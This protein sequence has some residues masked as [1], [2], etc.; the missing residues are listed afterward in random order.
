MGTSLCVCSLEELSCA[1][2]TLWYNFRSLLVPR[3]VNDKGVRAGMGY[4]WVEEKLRH[5]HLAYL[6]PPKSGNPQSQAL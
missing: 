5:D 1:G 3:I 2:H 4:S 6:L